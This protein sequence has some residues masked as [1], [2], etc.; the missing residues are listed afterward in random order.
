MIILLADGVISVAIQRIDTNRGIIRE[1]Y[2]HNLHKRKDGF[3]TMKLNMRS[4]ILLLGLVPLTVLAVITLIYT[5]L[6]FET[7]VHDEVKQ[8]LTTS[9]LALCEY[10]LET[11]FV[12][13]HDYIDSM[14]ETGVELTLIKDN[15][16]FYTTLRNEDGLRNEDTFIDSEVYA[17]LKQN[18][19]YYSQGIMIADEEYAVV[20]EPIFI[21][22]EYVGS[23]FAAQSVQSI[24]ADVSA[25]K[26]GIL[27]IVV[28]TYIVFGVLLILIA[29]AMSKPMKLAAESLEKVADGDLR[30]SEEKGA[31]FKEVNQIL[32]A[33]GKLRTNLRSIVSAI[34]VDVSELNESNSDFNQRFA[35]INENVGSINMAVEEV[36]TGATIQAQ[37][38]ESMA[39]Q[40]SGMGA[41]V[42]SGGKAV[43]NLEATVQTM[44]TLS[45]NVEGLVKAL[46]GI[47]ADNKGSVKILADSAEATNLSAEKIHKAVTLI[48]DIAS[49][50]NLLS[51]NASIEAA[52][53][54]EQGKGFAVVAG[55]IRKLAEDSAK[56]ASVIEGI[57]KEL[58]VNSNNSLDMTKKV[59]TDTEAE[60]KA[61]TEVETAFNSLREN[62]RDVAFASG[63]IAE[64]MINLEESR[65]VIITVVESL[66]AVSEESA[67]S[68]EETSAAMEELSAV[69]ENCAAEVEG[70]GVL[71]SKLSQLV[72]IFRL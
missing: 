25:L 31:I 67:A 13:G 68:T 70:L 32:T 65:G 71:S 12:Y 51:L 39:D 38:M 4:A 24:Y 23:A 56:N 6:K 8:K 36:A 2:L 58:V 63:S 45:E 26:L 34:K 22:N 42:D 30:E 35:E 52:R 11:D 1:H 48:Q 55:E 10:A 60:H 57:I 19:P 7:V 29:T 50:T 18:I 62:V 16:R 15:I 47:N 41:V 54:G 59:L 69:V 21:D 40:I 3:Y 14:Q 20:Y 61:L 72:S 49:Q 5:S 66:S 53:A 27:T 9:A 28:G 37:D 43:E 17:N 64:Q 44:N 33:T 46:V